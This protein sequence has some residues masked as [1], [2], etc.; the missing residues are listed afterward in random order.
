MG[1]VLKTSKGKNIKYQSNPSCLYGPSCLLVTLYHVTLLINSV[2]LLETIVLVT[3]YSE[4]NDDQFLQFSIYKTSSCC[5]SVN[6][7]HH[8]TQSHN[9]S[10]GAVNSAKGIFGIGLMQINSK[11]SSSQTIVRSNSSVTITQI[12]L[13]LFPT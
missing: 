12:F 4:T 6:Q 5:K 11:T 13:K 10:A 2:I 8:R 7:F 3:T 9:A 1:L